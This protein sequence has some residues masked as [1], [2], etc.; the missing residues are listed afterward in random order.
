MPY[1]WQSNSNARMRAVRASSW[2][3]LRCLA[4][5]VISAAVQSQSQA[6]GSRFAAAVAA[7][8]RPAGPQPARWLRVE[9]ARR[10]LALDPFPARAL[11]LSWSLPPIA[12]VYTSRQPGPS[13]AVTSAARVVV[14]EDDLVGAGV[15][16]TPVYDSGVVQGASVQLLCN[17]T[18]WLRPLQTYRWRV[19]HWQCLGNTNCSSLSPSAWS[20]CA[21]RRLRL[22]LALN[23]SIQ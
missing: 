1:Y 19:Q 10:P 18:G 7:P 6:S 20:T 3:A 22:H 2:S 13:S 15:D 17:A 9:N 8:S 16:Q 4:V 11:R 21:S 12:S 14:E 5:T 23:A